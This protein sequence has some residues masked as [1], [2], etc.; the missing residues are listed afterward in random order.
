MELHQHAKKLGLEHKCFARYTSLTNTD[1][2]DNN[3]NIQNNRNIIERTLDRILTEIDNN[4]GSSDGRQKQYVEYWTRQE[5]RHI[6]AHAD[7]D[8]NLSRHMD[9]QDD[10]TNILNDID[11]QSKYASTYQQSYGHR[12]PI[13]GHVLYLQV[14]T[15]VRGPTVVFPNRSSGG[16]LLKGMKDPSISGEEECS[17][18]DDDGVSMSIIP[19][20]EGRLLRFDGRDLH[21]VPRPTDIW[22]LPFVKG[23]AEYEPEEQWGRSVILFNV[24]PGDE[25]PPLDVPLDIKHDD[26]Q[27][28]ATTTGTELC[29]SFSNWKEVTNDIPTTYDSDDATESNQSVKIWL[30]G[31][32]R[33]RDHPLRTVPLLSPKDGGR[34]IVRKAL[35]EES[36]VTE[37]L[38]R[39]K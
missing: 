26:D 16:D 29:N 1:N 38:L 31:N 10:D 33:R 39:R 32:E 34:N 24:W 37:L 12:Y 21:T 7:V 30:L 28:T 19:A 2:K 18:E 36:K 11:L 15:D 6:E 14:G 25:E 13:F 3:I 8:E 23:G 22:M 27:Q 9:K 4:N 5:W 20:V 35:S 17:S